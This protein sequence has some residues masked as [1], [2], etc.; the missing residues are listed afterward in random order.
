MNIIQFIEDPNL[1]N[2]QSL[3]PAQKMSLKAVYGL[4]LN[5]AERK[6]FVISRSGVRLPLL[7]LFF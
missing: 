3:S 5:N 4:P 1:I 2:D 7:A 6:L